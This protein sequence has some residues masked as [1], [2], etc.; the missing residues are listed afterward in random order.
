MTPQI[1]YEYCFAWPGYKAVSFNAMQ[2]VGRPIMLVDFPFNLGSKGPIV[3]RLLS[4]NHI[5]IVVR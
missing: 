3:G 5:R 1:Q 2:E 4:Y